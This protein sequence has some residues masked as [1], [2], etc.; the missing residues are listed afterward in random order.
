MIIFTSH[1]EP[2]DK[3][4]S[5][6]NVKIAFLHETQSHTGIRKD[7]IILRYFSICRI[8]VDKL[9]LEEFSLPSL[10][11]NIYLLVG[12]LQTLRQILQTLIACVINIISI[13]HVMMYP[14]Q[15]LLIL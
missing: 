10:A 1:H 15:R 8:E 12:I 13:C 9:R 4:L 7:T 6:K 11:N 3:N 2:P 14:S 5:R